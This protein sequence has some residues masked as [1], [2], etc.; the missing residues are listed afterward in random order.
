MTHE[1]IRKGLFVLPHRPTAEAVQHE[2]GD[3][4]EV[5]LGHAD[6]AGDAEQLDLVGYASAL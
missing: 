4:D 5:R 6:G 2:H 1:L 3:Q